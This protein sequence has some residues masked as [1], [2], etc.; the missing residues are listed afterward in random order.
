MGA[1][2]NIDAS[3][4]KALKYLFLLLTRDKSGAEPN[5]YRK[6]S[7]S[8]L[9]VLIVLL[10]KDDCRSK[11]SYLLTRHYSLE[12]STEGNLSLTITDV[13][14]DKSIHTLVAFHISLDLFDT[15]K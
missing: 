11:E 9:E 8:L 14:A 1:E 12:S 10:G 15:L 6:V 7:Q 5:L 3:V 4:L 13:T 2:E